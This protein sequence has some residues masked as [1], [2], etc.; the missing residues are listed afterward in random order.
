M[1]LRPATG[2]SFRLMALVTAAVIA[3]GAALTPGFAARASGPR[4]NLAAAAAYLAAPDNLIGGHYYETVPHYADFG[5]TIDSALALAAAGDNNLALKNIVSFIADGKPDQSGRTA[6]YWT[7]IGT[8]F[9][10]GGAIGKE[11]LLAEV[12]GDNPDSFGGH[13]LIA[14][15][16][17]TV[18]GQRSAGQNGRCAGPGNY[19]YATS[20][21]DQALGVIA[22]VRAG[23]L[24]R[25]PIA[26]LEGLRNADGSFP[27]LIPDG[28]DHDV[29]STALAVMALALVHSQRA[30][31]DVASGI[32]WIARQQNRAGGFSGA[33]G[34]SVNST[35]LAIQALSLRAARYPA[36]IRLALAFLAS[37]Q[38]RDGGFRAAAVGPRGSDVRATAQA[39]SG[40][41]GISFGALARPLRPG[42][43]TQVVAA[44]RPGSGWLIAA[45]TSAAGILLIGALLT[46][47]LR[48]ARRSARG[49]VLAVAL[50]AGAGLALTAAAAGR[51]A[52]AA[53]RPVSDCTAG[54]GATVVVDFTHW[55]GPLLRAC[56]STPTTGYAL[57]NQGGWDTSGT[58]HDGPAFVCR[59]GYSGY[60]HGT[61]YPTPAQ[62]PCVDTPPA[63]AYWSNWLAGPGQDTWHYSEVGATAYHPRP[64]STSLW[65][66]GATNIGGTSGS[67]VPSMSPASMRRAA[68]GAPPA[69]A[70]RPGPRGS[71]IPTFAA[72]AIAA[73]LAAVGVLASRR[74]RPGPVIR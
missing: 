72:L 26:F 69:A 48:R 5:L 28:H 60:H 56:G 38:N 8:R 66:F 51:P 34:V 33:S 31:A 6:N 59:I 25:A 63:T 44:G 42:P 23:H 11:A 71:S 73:G 39:V 58:E 61:Q 67:A 13:D 40:A 65:I 30:R 18:C 15:L 1:L 53:A 57:L 45:M 9:A 3:A 20:V 4:P 29:D 7:G 47:R 32:G 19:S 21:F 70:G 41:T 27:S 35:G 54:S 55:G 74:R 14:A 24:D 16:A 50:I 46:P 10:S 22:Q 2:S 36:Q 43:A 68:A 37:E 52:F 49:L 64:G 12:V 62:E 17:A